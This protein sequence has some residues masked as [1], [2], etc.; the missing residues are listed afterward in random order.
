MSELGFHQDC[1]FQTFKEALWNSV[2]KLYNNLIKHILVSMDCEL[3]MT[4]LC[5]QKR[6]SE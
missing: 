6:K 2:Q 3:K 5:S 4:R 1:E